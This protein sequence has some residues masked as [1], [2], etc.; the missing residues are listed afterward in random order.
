VAFNALLRTLL[1]LLPVSRDWLH[2]AI[3]LVSCATL[4]LAPLGALAETNLRRAIAILL[5]G[6]I[7]AA[8]AGVAMPTSPGQAA[9]R[10]MSSIP[11]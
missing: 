6:G 11:C 8:I 1:M 2:P 4:L 5:I 7:G 9:R 10:P 3:A